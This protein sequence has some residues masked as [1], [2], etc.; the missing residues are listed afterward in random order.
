MSEI[1]RLIIEDEN[2]SFEVFVQSKTPMELTI[3]DEPTQIEDNEYES[4]SAQDEVIAN[5]QKVHGVIRAYTKY[6]IGAF[7]N[8]GS[9]EVEEI[10]LKFGLKIGGKAGIPILT[11]GSTESNFE[12]E[13]KCRFPNVKE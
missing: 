9:A 8:L 11:E 1:Q 10:T 6:A 2:E 5:L 13:V 12:I 7:K 3:S 4:Y